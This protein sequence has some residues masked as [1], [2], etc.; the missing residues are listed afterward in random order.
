MLYVFYSIKK[1]GKK[2][3]EEARRG[4]ANYGQL[5]LQEGQGDVW[6]IPPNYNHLLE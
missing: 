6:K 1:F 5:W 3:K 2:K 4:Q